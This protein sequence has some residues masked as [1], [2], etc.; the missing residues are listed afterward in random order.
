SSTFS[1]LSP[2]LVL[3]VA[4]TS[5]RGLF[6]RVRCSAALAQAAPD[7]Y[8]IGVII[9]SHAV[10]P[11]L[12]DSLPYDSE[13]DFTPIST[14][15]RMPIA[16]AVHPSH[17]AKN[18]TEF[19]EL[20]KRKPGSQMYGSPGVGTA[21]HLLG[22]LI[23][24]RTGAELRHIPYRGGAPALQDL[25]AGHITASFHNTNNIDPS[26]KSGRVRV[27]AVSSL[28]R[29]ASLPDVPTISETLPGFEVVEWY[30]MAGPKG[31]TPET[32]ARLSQE[33][34][35]VLGIL[36]KEKKFSA[37]EG[38]EL[39]AS[40]PQEFRAFLDAELKRWPPIVRKL[41]LKAE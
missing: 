19:L 17:P 11:G 10:N 7:G 15:V 9:S 33:I 21:G 16:I 22:V 27:L 35:R 26:V 41:G 34:A 29:A 13:K 40:S 4:H 24:E 6:M 3:V 32:T 12:H 30:G 5:L 8:T 2:R 36:A 1:C 39:K 23:N 18:F 37:E 14:L 25:L 31:M 38:M 20:A 28:A